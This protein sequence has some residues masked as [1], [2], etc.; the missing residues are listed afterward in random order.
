MRRSI[1][2]TAKWSQK[3]ISLDPSQ[4][5][6]ATDGDSEVCSVTCCSWQARMRSVNQSSWGDCKVQCISF[7]PSTGWDCHWVHCFHPVLSQ[8]ADVHLFLPTGSCLLFSL[9]TS[10][11]VL[12]RLQA[13]VSWLF[14][15]SGSTSMKSWGVVGGRGGPPRFPAPSSKLCQIW[16]RYWRGT[17]YLH[18]AVHRHGQQPLN[19]LGTNMTRSNLVP[20]HAHKHEAHPPRV[21]KKKNLSWFKQFW[22]YL[23]WFHLTW[24]VIKQ[25]SDIIWVVC[26][27]VTTV[28]APTKNCSSADSFLDPMM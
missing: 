1:Q 17:L 6:D 24:S 19:G 9:S 16:L 12:C 22:F 3:C 23:S 18:A 5:R 13:Q 28:W 2:L 4:W 25:T 14:H 27:K 10:P 7:E 8:Q 20:K 26:N 15:A 21:K 11:P